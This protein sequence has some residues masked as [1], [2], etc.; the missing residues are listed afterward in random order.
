MNS[1]A[2]LDV[3]GPAAEDWAPLLAFVDDL[4]R[5]ER[6]V[7][8][9]HEFAG[10]IPGTTYEAMGKE[11][12]LGR[13]RANTIVLLAG[14][15]LRRPPG[16]GDDDG[17]LR[18]TGRSRAANGVELSDLVRV[19]L[20]TQKACVRLFRDQG[21]AAHVDDEQL[22]ECLKYL[23]AWTAWSLSA[24]ITGYQEV[25]LAAATHV[26]RR[27]DRA[28]RQLL[29]GG[30]TPVEA[31]QAAV[32]CGLDPCRA[33]HVLRVPTEGLSI[34]RI[35]H[36]LI[37]AGVADGDV[38]RLA[39]LYGDAALIVPE[40]PAGTVPFAVGVSA[41]V[42]ITHIAEGFRL[43]TRSAEAAVRL[44]R[45]NFV[46]LADLSITAAIAVDRDVVQ[47][48]QARYLD[49]FADA[50]PGGT[51]ILDTVVAYLDQERNIAAAAKLLFVHM[52][53]VRYRLE[54]FESMT[55]CSLRDARSLTEVWWVLQ[56]Y[57]K[58]PL[59]GM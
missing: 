28:V 4:G 5:E 58:S 21:R 26:Q 34:D 35:R 44:G 2:T 42:G 19:T 55:G 43:A 20:A 38:N 37:G 7:E 49:P 14:V 51:C 3:R 15:K 53:T 13:S 31:T 1:T 25:A 6:L 17:E 57:E 59:P 22:I 8:W 32:E 39:T 29:A 45:T 30:M 56:T 10:E 50:G 41:P 9:L 52:N 16:A 11:A 54:R 33:Y 27:Q 24:L 46:T 48:L 23:D 47:I 12:F 36:A 40:L 18:T